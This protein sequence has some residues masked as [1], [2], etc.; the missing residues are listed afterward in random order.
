MSGVAGVV[1]KKECKWDLFY[2][3]DYHSHLGTSYGGIAISDGKKLDKKI[4]N[5]AKAQFKTHFAEDFDYLRMNGNA[6]IG[7]ISDRD[8]QPLIMQLRFGEYALCGVGYINNQDELAKKLI[9]EGVVFSEMVNGKVNQIELAAKLINKGKNLV[10]GIQYMHTQIDGSLSLLLLGKE[11]LYAARD[12]FGRSPL[13]L[14]E[15]DDAHIVVSETC[16]FKNLGFKMKKYLGPGEI[17]LIGENKVEQ[18]KK[19][20][21]V[22]QLCT[23]LY[24]YAGFPASEYEGKN[25][26]EFREDSGRI[27]AKRDNVK[28]DLVCGVADSGTAYAHGYSHESGIPVRIPL[29]KYTPGWA[30]SYVPPSQET[31]DLVA[32]MKQ[33]TADALIRDKR[34]VI[35]EDSI[36]RGTQLKNYLLVKLWNAGAK[37]IHVRPACPAL[38]FPCKFLYSTRQLDELFAR[39]VIKGIHGKHID[40]VKPYIDIESK[41]YSEMLKLMEKD[42]NVTTLRYQRLDDMISTT[43]LGEEALCTYCW[44]GKEVDRSK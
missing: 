9:D 43:G 18:I 19:P 3:V 12:K 36:V 42:L 6:G 24:V 44:T 22:L 10:E 5:I 29:L 7:V 11:G 23:F 26:E 15:K 39:R 41:E 25:V 21:S 8:T 2:A 40:N 32:L 4:H 28:V 1:S 33:V 30:R 17:V 35:T 37:E 14:A 20:E 16:S 31:R 13:V 38:M 27:I 34:M